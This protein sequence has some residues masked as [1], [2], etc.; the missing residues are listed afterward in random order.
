MAEYEIELK[1]TPEGELFFRIPDDALARLGWEEGDDL[2]FEERDGAVLIRKIKYES[3]ELEFDDEELLK[4]MKFAHES[5][6]TFNQLCEDAIR[7]KLD[8]I[9][10][11]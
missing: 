7:S 6:I 4:Y 10:S 1:E 3:V 8:E 5:G 9:N 2:K 11:E